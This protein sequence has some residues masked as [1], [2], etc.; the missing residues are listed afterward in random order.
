M[1]IVT[2]MHCMLFLY[3]YLFTIAVLETDYDGGLT[4]M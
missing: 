2:Y 3:I 4:V 1:V